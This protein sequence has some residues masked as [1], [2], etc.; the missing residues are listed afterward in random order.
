MIFKIT[1]KYN[2]NY[3]NNY[4]SLISSILN[5]VKIGDIINIKDYNDDF[6]EIQEIR[7]F[8][9]YLYGITDDIENISINEV[10]YIL[11]MNSFSD[12]KYFNI[13]KYIGKSR[14]DGYHLFSIDESSLKPFLRDSKLKCLG[15]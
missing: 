11:K 14:I 8:N 5:D 1:C 7:D 12:L 10:L 13:F 3:Y 15:L 6:L 4:N 2:T 9:D